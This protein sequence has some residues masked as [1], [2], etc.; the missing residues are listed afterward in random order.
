LKILKI[1]GRGDA[2]NERLYL[3]V[4]K[5][6]DIGVYIILDSTKDESGELSDIFRHALVLPD[7]EV[8]GGDIVIVHTWPGEYKKE[9][10]DSGRWAHNVHWG[11]K[12]SIWNDDGD[13]A[14]LIKIAEASAFKY[15]GI[16]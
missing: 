4:L 13:S 2:K 3:S 1:E 12:S 8:E 7:I 9:R 16:S 6:C 5:D 11:S 15:G 14:F 10:L